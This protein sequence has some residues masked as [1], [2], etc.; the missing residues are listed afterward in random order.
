METTLWVLT[1]LLGGTAERGKK[2]PH[3][4]GEGSEDQESVKKE[5]LTIEY[6]DDN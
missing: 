5:K 6:L 1:R 3:P 4:L 2:G